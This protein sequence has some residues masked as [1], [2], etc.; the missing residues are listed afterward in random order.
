MAKRTDGANA[1]AIA[2][3]DARN[4]DMLEKIEV[5]PHRPLMYRD[6]PPGQPNFNP[7]DI[8]AGPGSFNPRAKGLYQ[9]C[10]ATDYDVTEP[11]GISVADPGAVPGASTR[12]P[13]LT[14]LIRRCLG[15]K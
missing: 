14:V 5:L 4:D 15:A 12:F 11:Y 8:F 1:S 10:R 13:S 2:F 3:M 9:D 6:S 7:N